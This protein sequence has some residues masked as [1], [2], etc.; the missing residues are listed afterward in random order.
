MTQLTIN[1]Q[2]GMLIPAGT[3]LEPKA[4]TSREVKSGLRN[5]SF[6]KALGQGSKDKRVSADSTSRENLALMAL[7]T[8]ATK[9]EQ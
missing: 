8:T 3:P 5:L 2:L 1:S 4:I 6:S 9:P 7:L